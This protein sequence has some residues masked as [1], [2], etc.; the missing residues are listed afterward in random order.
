M[1]T[2]TENKMENKEVK[3]ES[4]FYRELLL[5]CNRQYNNISVIK[6]AYLIENKVF[7]IDYISIGGLK[8]LAT[9]TVEATSVI[10][11]V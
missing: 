1:K 2:Q 5:H 11:F 10:T 7:A 3:K 9:N 6:K 4:R 8:S